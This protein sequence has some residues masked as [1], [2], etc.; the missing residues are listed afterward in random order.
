MF[1]KTRYFFRQSALK[2]GT[3]GM[4]LPELLVSLILATLII[5]VVLSM[6][7]FMHRSWTS[8]RIRTRLRVNLEIAMER[9]KEEIRLSSVD[10]MS[11][12]K[13]GGASDYTAITFPM[14]TPVSGFYT[15]DASGNIDWDKSVIYHIYENPPDS[16]TF[17]L[18]RTVFASNNTVLTNTTQ[19]EAQ[20]VSVVTTGDGSAAT[21]STNASTDIIFTN[22]VDL[23][24]TPKSLEFDGYSAST[25]LSEN[26]FFGGI[27]LTP[28]NHAFKFL[29]IDQ[30]AVSTDY[31]LGIDSI[32]ISPSGAMR[33]G[34]SLTI[35]SSSGDTS[36][37]ITQLGWSGGK[38]LQYAANDADDFII[39]T[40]YYDEY[41]D[42]D[43]AN[44][45]RDST[46]IT[47]SDSVAQLAQPMQGNKESWV[48][49]DEAGGTTASTAFGSLGN[50]V[51]VR[52][53]LSGITLGEDNINHL[54]NLVRIKFSDPTNNVRIISAYVVERSS[55]ADGTGTAKQLYFSDAPLTIG[56]T[57]PDTYGLKIDNDGGLASA[58]Q[59][60]NAGYYAWSNWADF[61]IQDNKSYFVTLHVDN[62][63][64]GAILINLTGWTGSE[65]NSYWVDGD[66]A[67]AVVWGGFTTSSTTNNTYCV[68][69]AEVWPVQGTVTS[70]IYD[71]KIHAAST[72]VYNYVGW[73]QNV[74]G[75]TS[76]SVE[77]RSGD[78]DDLSD[79][80]AWI[81]VTN[82]GNPAATI[83][84]KRYVQFRATLQTSSPYT[85]F[86]WIDNVTIRWP[87]E[88]KVCDISGY[89]TRQSDYGIFKLLVD[90]KE[91]VKGLEY[92]VSV[93]D[94]FQHQT[95]EASLKS[96]A[97]PRNTGK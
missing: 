21:N 92:E 42:Y 93:Y 25:E 68:E 79:A 24:I 67:A 70:A 86:P 59:T 36:S 19:R 3:K 71:T 32:S 37:V 17:E 66:A 78:A 88:T 85:A 40:L 34:E 8:E 44:S 57:E 81:A 20:L 64:G 80:T 52:N 38:Y 95:I 77:V 28:G 14:A 39:F 41:T 50:G 84:G 23:T 11:L 82:G 2:S 18:R 26:I 33:E 30:N 74:P 75:G 58:T 46:I 62:G 91:L 35:A 5:G 22:L 97:E 73:T 7:Y 27:R 4:T 10:Y 47:G 63:V 48:A 9:L 13:A 6:W 94:T 96:E 65:V 1:R 61:Q 89:F 16:G 49:L 15:T 53:I 43:F 83:D 51:T 69:K 54:G 55:V 87:G 90:D 29:L 72:P 12:Y 31:G 60:I 45:I 76:V 56:T